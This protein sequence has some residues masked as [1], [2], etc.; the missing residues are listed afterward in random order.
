MH[1]YTC[2]LSHKCTVTHTRTALFMLSLSHPFTH[3]LT[4]SLTHLLTHSLIRSHIF[5]LLNSHSLSLSLAGSY[6]HTHQRS[7][8]IT[9]IHG[10]TQSCDLIILFSHIHTH[11]R[12]C[13]HALSHKEFICI[14]LGTHVCA[15][16]CV[17]EQMNSMCNPTVGGGG[18]GPLPPPLDPPLGADRF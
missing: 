9:F 8:T 3:S 12:A 16:A 10:L 11:T 1:M 2:S 15:L 6:R 14:S 17:I 13:I 4:Y 7:H 5:I 18:H